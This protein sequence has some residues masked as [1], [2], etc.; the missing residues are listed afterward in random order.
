[1]YRWFNDQGYEANIAAL[2]DEYPGMSS[3]EQYLRGYGWENAGVP[4]GARAEG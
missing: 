3:F 2:R 4:S 1:M